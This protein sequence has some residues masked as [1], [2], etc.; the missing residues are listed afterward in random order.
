MKDTTPVEF[1]RLQAADSL[2]DHP[3]TAT[4][5]ATPAERQALAR[6]LELDD[7]EHL[8]AAFTLTRQSKNRVRLAA[9]VKARLCQTCSVTGEPFEHDDAFAVTR[10]FISERDY[11]PT[12][13]PDM[14]PDEDD[15]PDPIIDGRIDIG[16]AVSEEL[17]LRIDPFA[18]K[19]GA[20]FA[21][22]APRDAAGSVI[23]GDGAAPEDDTPPSPFAVLRQLKRDD[24]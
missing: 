9:E 23:L 2:G 19:P 12:T 24:G 21:P 13:N 4:I 6:R 1:S 8:S 22:D 11:H 5:E 3:Y 20:V 17:A 15:P 7:L 18:R 14:D 16:E 10:D